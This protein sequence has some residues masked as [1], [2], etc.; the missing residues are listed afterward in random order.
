VSEE[1]RHERAQRLMREAKEAIWVVP[2]APEDW[3]TFRVKVEQAHQASPDENDIAWFLGRK[4]ARDGEYRAALEVLQPLWD[5]APDNWSGLTIA[6]CLDYLGHR[7]EAFRMYARVAVFRF[8]SDTQHAIAAAGVEAPQ[9]PKQPP[10]PP[11]GLVELVKAGWSA[12]ASHEEFAPTRGTDGKAETCWTPGGDH[13][14]P[15]MWYSLDLGEQVEGLAGLWL[16]DDAGGQSIYQNAAPRHCLVSVS[17]DGEWWKRVAGWQWSP[18]HYME[19]WWE[20][21]SARYV[22]LEQAA[23]CHPEW[24]CIYEAHVFAAK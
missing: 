17:R 2:T 8:L 10:T 1:S 3:A 16:D 23:Y 22:R 4:L 18:N 11:K 5:R 14:T 12:Q 9:A 20:P 7:E 19:S 15:E 21:I 6:Q 24:W 13:Q